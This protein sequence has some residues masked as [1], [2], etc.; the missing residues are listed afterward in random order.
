MYHLNDINL[1]TI[2]ALLHNIMINGII[3]S[4]EISKKSLRVILSAHFIYFLNSLLS[5]GINFILYFYL[6][7][8]IQESIT[9]M[10]VMSLTVFTF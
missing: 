9:N 1:F 6:L 8:T 3:L 10:C 7:K 4:A 2:I 5:Q